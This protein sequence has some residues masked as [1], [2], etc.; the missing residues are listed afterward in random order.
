MTQRA[1]CKKR[2]VSRYI[3]IFLEKKLS[4]V[5]WFP[6]WK[7]LVGVRYGRKTCLRK[8]PLT[9]IRYTVY[10]EV[11]ISLTT[12]YLWTCA[13]STTSTSLFLITTATI[14]YMFEGM[15]LT[16]EQ[17]DVVVYHCSTN[18]H[19]NSCFSPGNAIDNCKNESNWLLIW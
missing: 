12:T 5:L 7:F 2:L 19:F 1:I 15:T 4:S 13:Q 6:I 14:I 10:K 16:V 9:Q 11:P 18:N 3:P 8:T 17:V